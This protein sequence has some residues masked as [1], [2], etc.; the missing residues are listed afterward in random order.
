MIF[1][2]VGTERFPFDRLLRAIDEGVR[3]HRIDKEVF[4]QTG[5]SLYK[6]RSFNHESVIRFD[7]FIEIG[8]GRVL[9]GLMKKINRA[10]TAQNF[11]TVAALEQVS[12]QP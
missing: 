6:P 3:D 2:T 4:A 7:R 8:P 12:P 11:S 9:T 10:V 5:C 1:V